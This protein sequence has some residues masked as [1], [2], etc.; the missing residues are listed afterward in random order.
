M[1]LTN[2]SVRFHTRVN[3]IDDATLQQGKEDLCRRIMMMYRYRTD[4]AKYFIN[5]DQTLVYLDCYPGR[6]V[7]PRGEK[8][9]ESVLA[10]PILNEFLLL[11]V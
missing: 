11:L 8:A 3:Q 10:V 2:S 4:N 1:K 7:Q 6:K 9:Y 5:M